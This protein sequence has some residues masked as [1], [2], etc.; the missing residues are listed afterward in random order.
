M[1]TAAQNIE[2]CVNCGCYLRPDQGDLYNLPDG[3]VGPCCLECRQ[4]GY[5]EDEQAETAFSEN[6][7]EIGMK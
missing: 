3:T 4:T 2:F 6:F 7:Q 5:F 1:D